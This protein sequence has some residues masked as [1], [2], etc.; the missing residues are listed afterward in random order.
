MGGLDLD[1]PKAF[2]DLIKKDLDFAVKAKT[3]SKEFLRTPATIAREHSE[4]LSKEAVESLSSKDPIKDFLKLAPPKSTT[5]TIPAATTK[6]RID[7]ALKGDKFKGMRNFLKG[8]GWFAAADFLNNL[9]KGQSLT[10]AFNK[11]TEAALWGMKDLGADEKALIKHATEQGASEEEIGA[12]RYYLNYMKKYKTYETAN[13]MLHYAK[14][15]LGEGTGSPEDIGTTWEDVTSARE[16][17]KLREG[18]LENLYNIYAEG[19]P[20][21]QLGKNMLTKYIDSLA[22]EEWNKTAGT[23]IDR[24]SRTKQGEGLVWNPIGALT[25][26]IGGLFSGKMPTEFWDATL[27]KFPSLLDPRIKEK[28]KQ[29]RIMERPAVGTNYPEYD[30]AREDMN[31]DF[32]YALP[33]QNY[34]GG[35]IAGIRRPWAIPPES[36][37][38]PQGGGLSSQFNRVKKLTG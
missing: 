8:E 35:G 19:T 16:N 17:L 12:L 7:E 1:D 33:K 22:A 6:G 18:E 20:D 15:N 26:D 36:G 37:P 34:A 29:I 38:E 27:G 9:S 4:R 28:E 23:I 13:K 10:K 31:L 11:A 3:R 25:R 24:G 5:K 30:L 32:D 21:M 14:E 2:D